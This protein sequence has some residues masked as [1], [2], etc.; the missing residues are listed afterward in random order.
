MYF[1]DIQEFFNEHIDLSKKKKKTT[2]ISFFETVEVVLFLNALQ[3]DNER[4]CHRKRNTFA[5]IN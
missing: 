5:C 2:R 1:N 4:S 3:G